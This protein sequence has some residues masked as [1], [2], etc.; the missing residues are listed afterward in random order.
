MA[1][2]NPPTEL[3][4]AL[5]A[6]LET[7]SVTLAAKRLGVGQP[8]MSRTLE[9]LRE[10]TADALL[11]RT[12][13]GLARTR[14]ATD[15]LPHV[16]GL[17]SGAESVLA[18]APAFD[19]GTASGVVT[20][21]LGDD[22]QAMLAGRLL[23]RL[24]AEAPGLDVRVR[25][26]TRNIAH[27]AVRGVVEAFVMPDMRGAYAIPAVE[28]L[29]PKPEYVRRF[30]TVSRT[31]RKLSLDAFVAADHALVSPEGEEGGY[32]D[33]ALRSIGRRRR[34]AV[35]VP[36]FQA[37]LTLVRE[38]DLVA[39]LPD[40]V[41]RSLAPELHRQPCPVATPELTMC[42]WWASRFTPDARHR[43]LR[44]HLAAELCVLGDARRPRPKTRARSVA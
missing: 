10:V 42:V 16:R 40:D 18:P 1:G 39:T 9:K 44:G 12:G 15:L 2:M 25:P 11:V 21:A 22:M 20:I 13:R 33:D 17:V 14:H 23:T 3:L 29:V 19:P 27:D 41:L 4:P 35:T 7:E 5:L 37:A 24:R 26:I 6:L 43:W 30:V 31:R 32:V 28:D 8:A 36:T 34:V 38:S